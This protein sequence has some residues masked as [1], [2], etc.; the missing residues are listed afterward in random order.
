MLVAIQ[1]LCFYAHINR[2]IKWKMVDE[3]EKPVS[4]EPA[5]KVADKAAGANEPSN[6]KKPKGKSGKK[7]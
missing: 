3:V 1:L 7:N 4:D 6:Q 2:F 5:E